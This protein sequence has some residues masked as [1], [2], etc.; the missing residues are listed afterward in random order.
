MA[1]TKCLIAGLPSSGKSTYIGAL[2]YNLRNLKS[3]LDMKLIDSP[4]NLPEDI[5]HLN[6]LKDNWVKIKKIDRTNSNA[7]DN[8]QLNLV[9]KDSNEVLRLNIPDFLGETFQGIID[10]QNDEKLQLWC[11]ESESLL[12]MMNEISPGQFEDDNHHDPDETNDEVY[13]LPEL[14]SKD[15]APAAQNIMIL[16]Y[17]LS[18][19]VFRKVVIALTWWDEVTQNGKII[20]DPDQHLQ[21]T[22]PALYNFIKYRIPSAIIVGI[23]GQGRKYLEVN[24]ENMEAEKAFV[25]EMVKMTKEGKRAFVGIGNQISYDLSLPIDLLI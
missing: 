8:V 13:T 5:T 19:K 23:S 6:G 12:Y 1:E 10:L 18:Q 9:R 7:A 22:S 2:W 17:L 15:M 24:G 3:V 16:K 14:Q 25:D 4:E 11:K 20:V 21:S